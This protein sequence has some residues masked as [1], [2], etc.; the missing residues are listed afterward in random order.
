V[1]FFLLYLFSPYLSLFTRFVFPS[2]LVVF[3]ILRRAIQACGP[4][5]AD[6]TDAGP[7][8]G[9]F[10]VTCRL[11]SDVSADL[12]GAEQHLPSFQYVSE[13]GQNEESE[14]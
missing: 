11:C 2:Y 10:T 8:A 13:N 1:L 9:A 14:E 12:Q 3:L 4:I 6:D 7:I 5:P